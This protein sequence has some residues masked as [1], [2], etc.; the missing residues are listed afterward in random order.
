[1]G[2]GGGAGAQHRG[3]RHSHSRS[4]PRPPNSPLPTASLPAFPPRERQLEKPAGDLPARAPLSIPGL[5]FPGRPRVLRGCGGL[6]CA[7]L[8]GPSFQ[9]R[10]WGQRPPAPSRPF[11]P[12]FP[13]R[14]PPTRGRVC[15]SPAFPRPFLFGCLGFFLNFLKFIS[16]L[17]FCFAELW[18]KVAKCLCDA[19]LRVMAARHPFSPS[20]L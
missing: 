13:P 11:P 3:Q 9:H 19:C 16:W 8:P 1:M 17:L 18:L 7:P 4:H 12:S 2:A 15:C 14:I 5:K 20:L 10:G 6:L